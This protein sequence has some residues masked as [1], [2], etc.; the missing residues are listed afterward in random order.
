MARRSREFRG[1]SFE[2]CGAKTRSLLRSSA[3]S[4]RRLPTFT[5]SIPCTHRSRPHRTHWPRGPE[6]IPPPT[7]AQ[8]P[9]VAVLLLDR[10]PQSAAP[11]CAARAADKRASHQTWPAPARMPVRRAGTPA[12][13]GHDLQGCTWT[14]ASSPSRANGMGRGER[15]GGENP[16]PPPPP[17]AF[18]RLPGD[19]SSGQLAVGGTDARVPRA[20]GQHLAHRMRST[21]GRRGAGCGQVPSAHTGPTQGASG[22]SKCPHRH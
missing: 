11:S 6:P 5:S 18:L 3:S 9:C 22:H 2:K 4:L 7:I 1:T 21:C 10:P 19:Q 20:G 17:L 16:P 14:C 12:P 13:Q 15:A 8:Q